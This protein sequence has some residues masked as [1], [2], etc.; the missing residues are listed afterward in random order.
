MTNIVV[1]QKELSDSLDNF[2]KHELVAKQVIDVV[3]NYTGQFNKRLA[4][5]IESET[6]YIVSWNKNINYE[7]NKSIDV[8][9]WGKDI[10]YNDRLNCY[11]V[12]SIE[13]LVNSLSIYI[14]SL[15]NAMHQVNEQKRLELDKLDY[16]ESEVTKIK[17]QLNDLITNLTD[18]KRDYGKIS[19]KLKDYIKKELEL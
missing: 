6:G 14:E 17:N 1:L 9:I 8:Y 12:D 5:K 15:N 2:S 16:I 4:T 19:Y 7:Y 10:L 13:S 18:R 3:N 11:S